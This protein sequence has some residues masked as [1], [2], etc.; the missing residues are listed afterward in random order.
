MTVFTRVLVRIALVL[1]L[2]GSGP[3]A[4]VAACTDLDDI[5]ASQLNGVPVPTVQTGLRNA[6]QDVNGRLQD[7]LLGGYTR[8]AMVQLCNA[9]PRAGDAGDVTGTVDLAREYADLTTLMPNWRRALGGPLSTAV[10]AETDAYR[11]GAGR[12]TLPLRLAGTARMA[13]AVFE[14][15]DDLFPCAD[16]VLTDQP[17]ALTGAQAVQAVYGLQTEAQLCEMLPVAG[18]TMDDLVAAFARLGR[19]EA[20]LPGALADLASE[21]FARRMAENSASYHLRL[22]GT[23]AAVI[24]LIEDFR[25]DMRGGGDPTQDPVPET[26]AISPC[27]LDRSESAITYYTLT[28]EDVDKLAQPVDLAKLLKDFREANPEFDSAE[29][30]WQGLED[31]LQAS[32]DPCLLDMLQQIVMASPELAHEFY[33]DPDRA[34]NLIL[35]TT[36]QPVLPVVQKFAEARAASKQELLGGIEAALT[37][38]RGSAVAAEVEQ[39]AEVTAAAA[40]PELVFYDLPPEGIEIPELPPTVPR[41]VVTGATDDAVAA[42]VANDQFR[43]VL[44]ETSFAPATA[45]ELIKTQVRNAL[46]GAAQVE[47]TK[48]VD[49]LIAN[50]TPVVTESWSLTD[51]LQ[52]QIVNHPDLQEAINNPFA[53]QLVEAT[54]T[55]VGIEYPNLRLFETAL[56]TAPLPAGWAST[57]PAVSYMQRRLL[58]SAR[59]TAPQPEVTRDYGPISAEDCNCIPNRS[60]N[61]EVYGFYPFWD[62]RLPAAPEMDDAAGD[63]DAAAE[64]PPEATANPGPRRVDFGTVSRVAFYGLELALERSTSSLSLPRVSM[65]YEHQ[66]QAARQ[67]FVNSAHRYRAKADVS[68]DL[69]DWKRWSDA[70]IDEAV[71]AIAAQLTRFD[72]IERFDWDNLSAALPTVF[73]TPQP[74]GVTLFFRDYPGTDIRPSEACRITQLISRLY[75]ALPDR[76]AQSINMAV[77]LDLPWQQNDKWE[78][79]L[80]AELETLLVK[81]DPVVV[82]SS[83]RQ[84]DA[85]GLA[86]TDDSAGPQVIAPVDGDD[87]VKVVDKVLVF[88]ER[89]TRSAAQML[90][91][92]MEVS[93]F[94]GNNLTT[95]LRSVIPVV[96]PGA[97][98][99][100]GAPGDSSPYAGLKDEIV[101][102]QD[103]FG[104]IGFWSAPAVS[105]AEG[106]DAWQVA[107]ALSAALDDRWSDSSAFLQALQRQKNGVCG[108]VCPNRGS[109]GLAAI[110][111]LAALVVL[112]WRSFYS[113]MA[114]RIA[115]RVLT[116]GVVWIGNVVLIVLLF[117]LA[118]CDPVSYTPWIPFA[119]LVVALGLILI[120]NFVQ[121]A[122]NGPMP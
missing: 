79:P 56:T 85:A 21:D 45:P 97:H 58:I 92:Q 27:E 36:V 23:E 96:P 18:T 115:F 89:P 108:Y 13:V 62:A 116:I 59:K 67:S 71:A 101:Y 73:D 105:A 75:L 95:A 122:K 114:D 88:V 19:I 5:T 32:L 48:Q 106:D 61:A 99:L 69:H 74:D 15:R 107:A 54:K 119:L 14:Q 22:T 47:T 83:R 93:P 70:N 37:V 118:S 2:V 112:T 1:T 29:A 51:R 78:L 76:D 98:R 11:A 103:N 8:A 31:S 52:E 81:S 3:V 43:K 39:A 26:V 77:D 55:L 42:T 120:Y 84:C 111:L 40:E 104:G 53:P 16:A 64:A 90:R 4:A 24:K 17:T 113:G 12:I 41:V 72:R 57:D 38:D 80:F 30:L 28:Q 25:A 60:D 7:G 109:I 10:L 91:Y 87:G 20:A 50:I 117:L 35:K 44:E 100:I 33:L 63:G 34:Q 110:A 46:S 68:V 86:A 94:D 66:W 6:L 65:R 49:D 9:V 102:F 121:R 82:S